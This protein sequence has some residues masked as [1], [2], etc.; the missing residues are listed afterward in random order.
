M[1]KQKYF[2]TLRMTLEK[3]LKVPPTWSVCASNSIDQPFTPKTEKNKD[4]G[5]KV[6]ITSGVQLGFYNS[7]KC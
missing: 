2:S 4:D 6:T 3:R 7:T 5:N 1:A